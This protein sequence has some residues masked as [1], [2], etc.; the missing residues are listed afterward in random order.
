[1]L[2][3]QFGYITILF[4]I[5][6]AFYYVRDTLLGK[7]KPN[8]VSWFIWAL[9]P[10]IGAF[11]Q[12]KSGAG[13]SA[14]PILIEG[15][16]SFLILSASFYNKNAY[17]KI[18][19]LDVVCGA[20]S[21]SALILWIITQKSELSIIFVIIA[22]G[23]AALPT[24]LKSWKYPETETGSAYLF[25]IFSNIVGLLIIREWTFSIFSLGIYFILMNLAILFCIY[26]K[27]IFKIT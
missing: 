8:R 27:K 13:L 15:L 7:T 3:E 9:A 23:L 21:I 19:L 25:A 11:L 6:G 1:M 2:P 22:D 20:F 26:R 12:V 4:G 16:I 5:A 10:V 17:W 14:L 24:I 18:T